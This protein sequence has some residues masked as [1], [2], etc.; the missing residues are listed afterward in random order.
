M[1]FLSANSICP[2]E[3]P[4]SAASHLGLS[5]GYTVCLWAVINNR[6]NAIFVGERIFLQVR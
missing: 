4:R 5:G 2:A 6:K 1:K 3:T